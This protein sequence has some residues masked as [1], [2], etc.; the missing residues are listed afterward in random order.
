MSLKVADQNNETVTEQTLAVTVIREVRVIDT[1]FTSSVATLVSIIYINF[2]CALDWGSL[3]KNL[4]R[5]IGPILGLVTQF[6]LMPTV[7]HLLK[8]ERLFTNCTSQKCNWSNNMFLFFKLSLLQCNLVCIKPHIS[9][10]NDKMH[11]HLS[12][13]S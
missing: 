7:S 5:P 2:G 10:N 4:K 3:K 6:G 8:S 1:V 13:P 9:V 12:F 11:L